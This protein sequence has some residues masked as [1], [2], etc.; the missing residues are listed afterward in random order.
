MTTGATVSAVTAGGGAA[1][2]GLQVGDVITK[3]GE[4]KVESADALVAAVRSSAPNS[5][6]DVTYT[7]DGAENTVSVTLGSS[8]G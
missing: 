6:V 2:A 1:A 8:T 3:L 7:R 4:L 5:A